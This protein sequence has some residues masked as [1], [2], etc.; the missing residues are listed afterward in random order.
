MARPKGQPK[1]GGRIKGTP[2]KTTK[3][4]KVAIELA[5]EGIGGAAGLQA[6]AMANPDLFYTKI[7][8]RILPA[9]IEGNLA[10]RLEDLLHP[11]AKA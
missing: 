6:W 9:K 3:D 8:V 4:A 7:W 11:K 5:F 1:L 10:L 2:N